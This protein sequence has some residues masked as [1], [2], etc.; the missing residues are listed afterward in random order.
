MA[1]TQHGLLLRNRL[2][3]VLPG[4]SALA[5]ALIMGFVSPSFAQ[6]AED[7]ED[8]ADY[9]QASSEV[10]KPAPQPATLRVGVYYSPL[11]TFRTDLMDVTIERLKNA[12]PEYAFQVVP[13]SE[14]DLT[15]AAVKHE[16]DL[17]VVTSGLYTYLETSGA[18]ALAVRKSPQSQDPGKAMGAVFIARADD[19]RITSTSD[20]RSKRV[21]AL[22]PQ[23]FA[24]WIV[25]LGEIS[26]ITQYPKN[27]FGKA[28]FKDK[29]GMPIVEAVLNKEVDFGILRT[30]EF[31]SLVARGLV[32]PNTIKV[33]G[34][35]PEDTFACLRSTDLY[36]DLI[37]AAQASLSPDIK[38]R[39]SAALLSMPMSESG[40]G[41]TV[42]ANLSETRHLVERLGYSPTVRMTGSSVMIDRYK[43]ALLIGVLLLAAAVLYSFA[44]SR[45]VARRT[46]KLVEV[47]DEKSELE[48][49][50]R[51]D[52][53][54]LSQLERAGFVSEISSMI[55]HELRQPVASL[56][57]YA[58]GLSLYLGGRGKDPVIDEATREITKQAER[59]AS[60]VDRVR[61]YA[62]NREKAHQSVDLCD[63][64]K[65]AFGSFRS[66]SDLTGVRILSSLPPE[67]FVSG[68]ALELELLVVNCLKNALSAIRKNPD[69][70]GEIHISLTSESSTTTAFWRL[71]VQDNGP[72]VSDEQFR[73][74][75]RPVA[76]EKIEGL[77]LG[78]SI[79]R[80]IAERH[81][82]RLEFTRNQPGGLS[83]SLCIPAA[84]QPHEE[85]TA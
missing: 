13:L 77:G 40:Y 57:N 15:V 85:Q 29:S 55:A 20:L 78:L 26:N 42:G 53:E 72:A 45:T 56:I 69:G 6:T 38:R 14:F 27:Y 24:G 22:S 43:Y 61:A 81:A 65:H 63:I 44:V 73:T 19:A 71:K 41:W 3:K 68:D 51:I 12:M 30:C 31:E 2:R 70:K 7:V 33:V 50:A 59:V 62:K 82:A 39:L 67:A 66:G 28:Y 64:V 60:I 10:R 4:A 75:A 37:F 58:D 5:C 25:A 79:S 84:D 34:K 21:A 36:P 1:H 49:T 32:A 54:R 83:V 18:T 35:K 52:R 11:F 76:S 16:V 80:T 23:S 9:Q 74:L 8:A 47:I 17:F 46:K 48:K